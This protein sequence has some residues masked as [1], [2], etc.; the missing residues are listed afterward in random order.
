MKFIKANIMDKHLFLAA[1]WENSDDKS[2]TL[3]VFYDI[4]SG[5]YECEI[6]NQLTATIKQNDNKEWIDA[7]TGQPSAFAKKA[8]LLINKRLAE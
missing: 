5:H 8:G 6:G 2:A 4:N 1:P 7:N 3:S